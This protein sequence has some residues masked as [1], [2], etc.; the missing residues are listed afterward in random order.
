MM[1]DYKDAEKAHGWKVSQGTFLAD[2]DCRFGTAT[3]YYRKSVEIVWFE[4]ASYDWD[5]GMWVGKVKLGEDIEGRAQAPTLDT[6]CDMLRAFIE[7]VRPNNHKKLM[8]ML[9]DIWEVV[10]ER[11]PYKKEPRV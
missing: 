8:L 5:P 9:D 2:N 7:A 11:P 1:A 3:C 6:L 10:K 4:Q